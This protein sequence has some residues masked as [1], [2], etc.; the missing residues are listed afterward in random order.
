MGNR[1]RDAPL[2]TLE[3]SV[4]NEWSSSVRFTPAS[5]SSPSV[6]RAPCKTATDSQLSRE[7]AWTNGFLLRRYYLNSA[8]SHILG[9]PIQ[10]YVTENLDTGVENEIQNNH[11]CIRVMVRLTPLSES[12]FQQAWRK[13]TAFCRWI[14]DGYQKHQ[15]IP[16]SAAKVEQIFG[17]T[18][19]TPRTVVTPGVY[20][21]FLFMTWTEA[22]G[23]FDKHGGAIG[24]S[25]EP[26]VDQRR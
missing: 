25:Y 7:K 20:E 23:L 17:R 15:V 21:V 24:A 10:I 4:D 8:G 1:V 6:K 16:L 14:C 5:S 2:H 18:Q 13:H 26:F 19:F 9:I 11:D 12:S 22:Q 3:I